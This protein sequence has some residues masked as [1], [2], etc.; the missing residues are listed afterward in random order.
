MWKE[1]PQAECVWKGMK[2]YVYH[3]LLN[4]NGKACLSDLEGR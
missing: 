3:E 4:C 2:G 1:N